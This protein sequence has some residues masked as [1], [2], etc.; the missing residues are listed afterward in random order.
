MPFSS[1]PVPRWLGVLLLLAVATSF[2]ANHVAA[3]VAFD[4]GANVLAAVAFR[5]GGTAVAVAALMLVQGVSMRAGRGTWARAGI[6]GVI[7]ATQSVCLYSAVARIPVALALLV[8]NTFPLLLSLISWLSGGERPSRRMLLAMPV[9]LAGLTLALDAGGWSTGTGGVAGRW[10]EIGAGVAF[11]LGAALSFATALFLTTRWLGG[12]DGRLRA[13]MTMGTV[14]LLA[15]TASAAGSALVLPRDAVGWA[16][17][18]LLTLFY[19]VAFTSLFALLPRLGAVNNAALMNFEPIAV[20]F[21]AWIVLGQTVT[22][23]QLAG[24]AIVVGAIVAMA[25][26]K[27]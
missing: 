11:A 13:F 1:Q 14:A 10:A 18:V 6:V 22:P 17:I 24:A 16:G 21:M 26:A 23:L 27:A 7:V 2:G 5:S 20:L 15:L 9:A 19:G 8:F 3:R 12:V 25:L 4:H